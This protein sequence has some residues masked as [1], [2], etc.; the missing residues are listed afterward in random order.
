MWLIETS[1][2]RLTS[3]SSSTKCPPYAILSHAWGEDLDEVSF[4]EM[5]LDDLSPSTTKKPG[6]EKI[7]K[8]CKLARTAHGLKYTWVDT[9]CIDKTSSAELSE[10]INSMFAWYE[11]ADVCFAFLSDLSPDSHSLEDCIWFKRGWTLQELIAPREVIFLDKFWAKRGSK[12]ANKHEIA[13]ISG[14]AAGI[15]DRTLALVDIPVAVRM[16]WAAQRKTT[17][18]EDL[19]YC[20]LGIFDVNMPMLYGEGRKAFFRLQEEIIKQI[21]DL[22]IFAWTAL[23]NSGVKYTGLLARE[24][25]EFINTRNLVLLQEELDILDFSITNLGIRIHVAV[26]QDR[27]EGHFILPVNLCS[28]GVKKNRKGI[29]LRQIGTKLFVR[30]L[31]EVLAD[32]SDTASLCKMAKSLQIVKTLMPH[33]IAAIERNVI[34]IRIPEYP[35]AKVEPV[36]CWDPSRNML[37][38]GH[39]GAFVGYIHFTPEW[40]DEYDSYILVCHFNSSWSTSPWRFHLECGDDWKDKETRYSSYYNL[41]DEDGANLQALELSLNLPHLYKQSVEMVVTVRAAFNIRQAPEVTWLDMDVKQRR[42]A[43]Y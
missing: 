15:L 19:A 35:I 9:C 42:V 10:A 24:P 41:C 21:P 25:A 16:S 3:F 36:G 37:F 22:S 39:T 26:D 33:Q 20:L 29:Y 6:F 43:L 1:T 7:A 28:S 34:G 12:R 30:A 13:K 17:R 32:C 23:P 8:T 27:L 40:S 14:V 5:A 38:A 31:P 11:Q 2:L 18:E 4:Q